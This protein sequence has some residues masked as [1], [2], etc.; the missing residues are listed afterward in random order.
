MGLIDSVFGLFKD[1]R[2]VL[3]LSSFNDPL[4]LSI[5]WKPLVGG[6]SNFCTHRLRKTSSFTEDLACF[7]VTFVAFL[8]CIVFAI[9]G[10]VGF[11]VA[12]L[13]SGDESGWFFLIF[14]AVGAGMLWWMKRKE[15]SFCRSSAYYLRAGV[16]HDASSL[17]A[18][19][20]VREYVSGNKHSYYSYE[21]NLIMS[22]GTRLNVTDHG[23]LRAIRE[24]A[25]DLS[26][27][28]GIPVWDAIDYRLPEPAADPKAK[29]SE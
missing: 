16:R 1:R 13:L 9:V 19:Q 15:I 12:L 7:K 18:I 11:F 8:F 22:D 14:L 28:L 3:D 24:D 2:E 4:A 17:H 29:K 6:G 10:F 20:L 23:S 26:A 27:Y 21:L 25:H 5:D